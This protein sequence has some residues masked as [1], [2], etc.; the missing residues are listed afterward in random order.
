MRGNLT[1]EPL[2]G[3]GGQFLLNAAADDMTSGSLLFD[4]AWGAF[5]IFGL[6][7]RDGTTHPNLG[8]GFVWDP[9]ANQLAVG[10]KHVVRS[11]NGALAD[12]A[13]N[14]AVSM[15]G[16]MPDYSKG[17]S[18]ATD[19]THTA[20]CDGWLDMDMGGGGLGGKG[21]DGEAHVVL[22]G[23]ITLYAQGTNLEGHTYHSR[24]YPIPKGTTFIG[25]MSGY[26]KRCIMTFYPCMSA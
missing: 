4:T 11:V 13:G 12:A 22:N 3:E 1:L 10:D 9:H 20:P 14:V 25:T 21:F 8:A 24:I 26:N 18:Y 16:V 15:S 7:S 5:R 2:T 6:P 19:V 23:T 17:T